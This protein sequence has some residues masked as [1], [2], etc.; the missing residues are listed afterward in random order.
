MTCAR[1]PRN[2]SVSLI[3]RCRLE[4]SHQI[5]ASPA[6]VLTGGDAEQLLPHFDDEVS[7][8][9]WLTLEGLAR[10]ALAG[11]SSGSSGTV[12]FRDSDL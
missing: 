2:P 12:T 11:R 5:G 6:L 3:Q 1:C 8:L 10:L 4:L 7:F 9:P